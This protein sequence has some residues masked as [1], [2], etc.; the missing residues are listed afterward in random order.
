MYQVTLLPIAEKS[1][2]DLD[3]A[4]QTRVA[5]RIDWLGKFSAEMIHHQL[6]SMPDDLKGLCKFKVG[7]YR[8]LYWVYHNQK[9]IKIYDIEHR[10]R[11][12]RSVR[13]K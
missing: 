11:E 12:Y 8:I 6:S 7:D 13:R 2:T 9:H 10:G 1:F 4:G 3:K 5:D